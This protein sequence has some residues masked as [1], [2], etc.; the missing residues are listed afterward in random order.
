MNQPL[1]QMDLRLVAV[2]VLVLGVAV[3]VIWRAGRRLRSEL[4]PLAAGDGTRGSLARPTIPPKVVR[5]LQERGLATPVQLANMSEMERQ[6]LFSSVSDVL[7]KADEPGAPARSPAARSPAARALVSSDALPALF[8][9]TCGDRIERFTSEPPITGQCETCRAK[10][11]VRR[12]GAR[13]LLTV[14]PTDEVTTRRP[15]TRLES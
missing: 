14:Q 6:L 10:V 8:C 7:T 12:E 2:A 15:D 5:V 3:A 1:L 4:G 13:L 11:V 9:P